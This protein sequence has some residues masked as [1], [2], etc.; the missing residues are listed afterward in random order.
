KE[1]GG[2][3]LFPVHDS[4]QSQCPRSAMYAGAS[5]YRDC[6]EAP[7]PEMKNFWIPA[8]IKVGT[9]E[10]STTGKPNWHDTIPWD[11]WVLTYGRGSGSGIESGAVRNVQGA[12]TEQASQ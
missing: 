3:L 1:Y 8:V 6:M 10:T 4:V 11:D 5:L 7:I 9:K 2:R 12:V